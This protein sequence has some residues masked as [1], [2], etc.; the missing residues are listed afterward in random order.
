MCVCVCVLCMYACV[1][2][3]KGYTYALCILL[4]MYAY[5]WTRIGGKP[6]ICVSGHVMDKADDRSHPSLLFHPI[7]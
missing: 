1:H 2:I 5:V 6:I 4:Y 7:C 3:Q